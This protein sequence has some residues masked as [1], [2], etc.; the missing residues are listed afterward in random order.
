MKRISSRS[1]RRSQE[2]AA[3]AARAAAKPGAKRRIVD[4]PSIRRGQRLRVAR[5]DE[6]RVDLVGQNLA[7]RR[8]PRRDD[9]LAGGHVFEQ[10]ERRRR[11]R[12]DR[13]R[14]F[15]SAGCR[16]ARAAPA[17]SDGGR[18]PVNV[19]RS[20]MRSPLAVAQASRDR[21]LLV[22]AD[23]EAAHVRHAARSPRAARRRPS[24]RRDG[25]RTRS[26]RVPACQGSGC[27]CAPGAGKAA[28]RRGRRRASRAGRS[29]R[30]ATRRA[31]RD[32]H[33]AV[34]VLPHVGLAPGEPR[35]LRAVEGRA[36]DTSSGR[37]AETS[38]A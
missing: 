12:R 28:C 36:V 18:C 26:C 32:G 2:L 13:R 21:V 5:R 31:R 7:E 17:T 19:T 6:Q 9:G 34:R 29:G 20:S 14:G 15:G 3:T 37:A 33:V 22:A 16:R 1:A 10:L 30:S 11:V 35:E 8:Q 25:P 38:G 24:R 4:Q 27:Q 23:D